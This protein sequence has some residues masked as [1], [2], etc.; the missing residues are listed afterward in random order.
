MMGTAA[1]EAL[2]IW[3]IDDAER[4]DQGA[5]VRYRSRRDL[6]N[7]VVA[8]VASGDD[9]HRFKVAALEKTIAYPLDPWF[10]FGDPRLL[11]ALVFVA[12]GLAFD[13]RRLSRAVRYL[14]AAT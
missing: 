7:Q 4:W 10:H 1:A 6:M 14:P 9:I 13:V 8:L 11:L 5:L 3:G 12:I 2:D